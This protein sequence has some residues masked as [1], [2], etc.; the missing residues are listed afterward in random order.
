MKHKTVRIIYGKHTRLSYRI[1]QFSN[2]F[3]SWAYI[4][5]CELVVSKQYASISDAIKDVDRYETTLSQYEKV[6]SA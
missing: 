6:G 5:K 2:G 4:A 1:V 3:Y